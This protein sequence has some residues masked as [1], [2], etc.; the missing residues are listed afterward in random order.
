[1]GIGACLDRNGLR[2]SR[3]YVT[4]DDRVILASE[5]G[6]LDVPAEMVIHK[7]RLE[8]GACVWID[9]EEGRVVSD[10]EI[11]DTISTARPYRKWLND[12]MINLED[13]PDPQYLEEQR[14]SIHGKEVKRSFND[15][16]H[17]DIPMK[18]CDS[19]SKPMARN[20]VEPIGSMGNDTP[21]AVLSDQP[22]LLF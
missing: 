12:F 5:A 11:K 16:A 6:V 9:T 17:S 8:P 4:S 18:I 10:D 20:G 21:L 22:V 13:L 15:N 1:M 7:G 2:P 19:S 14:S 3:Y